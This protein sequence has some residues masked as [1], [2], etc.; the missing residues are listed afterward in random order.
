[1]TAAALVWLTIFRG[2]T[3][4]ASS[5]PVSV[6]VCVAISMRPLCASVDAVWRLTSRQLVPPVSLINSMKS[7]ATATKL[8]EPNSDS[9]AL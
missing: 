7:P 4:R 9:V 1:M 2:V 5:V 8:T 6:S 3:A